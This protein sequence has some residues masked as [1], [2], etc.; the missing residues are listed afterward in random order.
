MKVVRVGSASTRV[1][2]DWVTGF[3]GLY[4]QL[5]AFAAVVGPVEVD[6]DDLVQEALTR[7]LAAGSLDAV[8]DVGAY[9]RRTMVN[10]SSNH[11][12]RFARHRV[13]M[14]RLVSA[15]DLRE[16]AVYPSDL[17]DLMALEPTQRA[18]LFLR[19]VEGRTYQQISLLLDMSEGAVRMC[20]S[21]ARRRLR[22]ALEEGV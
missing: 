4:P 5:R 12:R 8:E 16:E 7:A 21:R 13:A 19:E 10:L 17:E 1:T 14:T 18:V 20:A 9:L 15:A 6:P 3:D 11:R 2:T 22:V